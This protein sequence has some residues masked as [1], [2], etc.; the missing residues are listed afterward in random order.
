LV[1]SG[2]DALVFRGT[3]L[4]QT[5]NDLPAGTP[6]RS[7]TFLSSD[8]SISGNRLVVTDQIFVGPGASGATIAAEMDLNGSVQATIIGGPLSIL[9]AVSGTGS[10][11][12]NGNGVLVLGASATFTGTTTIQSGATLQ[13][14]SADALPGAANAGA[15]KVNG[16][17][18]LAGYSATVDGLSGRGLITSSVPGLVTLSVDTTGHASTFSGVIQDGAGRVALT[19][20]GTGLLTLRGNNTFTGETTVGAGSTLRLGS[21]G[22]LPGDPEVNGTL[23]LGGYSATLDGLW[24]SGLVT[25]SVAG[26]VTLTVDT[27]NYPGTFSGVIE[28]GSGTVALTK[29]G[30]GGLTLTGTNTYS[31]GT[32]ISAGVLSVGS[33]GSSGTLGS[34]AVVNN[35]SLVFTRTGTTTIANAISGSGTMTQMSGTVILTGSNTYSGTTTIS[36]TGY[37]N[38]TL[39]IGNGGTTG[40]LGSGTVTSDGYYGSFAQLVY[41]RSDGITASNTITGWMNVTVAAGSTLRA[42]SSSGCGLPDGASGTGIVTINGTFDLN[43][44]SPTVGRLS[45]GGTVT[46]GVS[47]AATLTVDTGSYTAAFSGGIEDGSGTVALTKVGE[48]ELTLTGTNTYSGGT[49]IGAGVLAVGNWGSSGTLGSGAVVNNGS[50]VFKRSGTATVASAISGSGTVTQMSG[51]VILTGSNTYSGTTTIAPTGYENVTLQIGNG[52]TTGTL[53]SGTVTSDG[54]YESFAQLAYNRSDGMTSSNAITGGVNVTVAAGSTLRAGSSAACGLP[55]GSTGTGNATINGVFDLNGYSPTIGLLNGSGTV[56][57]GVSG[58]VTLTVDTGYYTATF[59]GVIEDGSGTVALTKEGDGD[60]R[61]TGTNTYSGDTTISAGVLSVGSWGSSGTLGS[62]A[63]VNNSSLAF[64]RSGTTTVAN[65]ISGS[66]TVTQA[67]GTLTLTG[68]N[69]YTGGTNIILG[70]TLR[71]GGSSGTLGSGAVT[72]VYD[73][74]HSAGQLV[75]DRSVSGTLTNDISGF[76][77]VA[78]QGSGA[79]ALTGSNTYDQATTIGTGSTLCIG[80]GGTAGTVGGGSITVN[81]GGVLAFDRSDEFTVSN[82]ISGS[83]SLS[84]EGSGTLILTGTAFLDGANI[85]DGTLQVEGTVTLTDALTNEGTLRV[86]GSAVLT[87]ANR[88]IS[89]NAAAVSAGEVF[90][91]S[92]GLGSEDATLEFEISTDGVNY[93]SIATG[94]ETD[95]QAMLSGLQAE[96]EYYLRGRAIHGDGSQEI[97]DGG[98]VATLE[99]PGP[100][101]ADTSGWYRISVIRYDYSSSVLEPAPGSTAYVQPRL[102]PQATAEA[103]FARDPQVQVFGQTG[104]PP[105]ASQHIFNLDHSWFFSESPQAAVL[106]AVVGLVQDQSV[107][108]LTNGV[109]KLWHIAHFIHSQGIVFET[110]TFDEGRYPVGG[111]SDAWY[112][113]PYTIG[114][115]RLDPPPPCEEPCESCCSDGADSAGGVCGMPGSSGGS[116]M[117]MPAVTNTGAAPACGSG[118]AGL[119]YAS[120]EGSLDTGFGP[121]WSDADELPVLVG[122]VQNMVARFGA[123]QTVWFDAQENGSYTARHGAKDTLVHD[124]VNDLFILTMPDGSRSEFFDTD[125]TDHPQGGL[126]RWVQPGGATIQ[127]TAWT[128]TGIDGRVAEVLD[129]TT[130][131]GQAYLKREFTYVTTADGLDHVQTLTLSQYDDTSSEWAN[132]RKLTYDY[133]GYDASYGLP[134][135]LKTIVTEQWDATAED[136]VG[137]DTNYFRYYT[138][139]STAHQLKRVVLPNAYAAF[140]A[141]YGDPDDPYNSNAGD[142]PSDPLA[143]YT[144]FYYEYDA[145]GRVT[146]RLVFGKSNETED[147]VTLST[148]SRGVNSWYRKTV[149]SRLDGSTNTVY[150]NF[151]GQAILTD[152]ADSAENH[153]I[154]YHRYDADGRQVLTAEPSAFVAQSGL[155]YDEDMPD[156][157]DYASGA[158][159]YLSNTAG[160]FRETVYYT[161]DGGGAAHGYVYQTAV[162][163]GETAA[164]L[165][166]GST[167]GPIVL[168]SYEYAARTVGD[169]TIHPVAEQTVYTNEDGTGAVTTAYAYTWYSGTFQVQEQTTTLPE[170]E[171]N[172]NGS[173]TSATSKQWFDDRG[174][175]AWT[176]DELGRVTYRQYDSLTGRLRQTIEDLDDATADA[177]QLDIPAGW[178]LPASGGANQTTDYQYDAFGRMTQSLGPAHTADLEGTPTDVRTATWTFYNDAGHETRSAQGYAV[179]SAPE[180]WD[181]FTI[182]GPV[183]IT[184]TDRDGR[185]TGQIQAAYSGT[186]SGLATATIPQSD[187]TAWTAF[188]Y[189]NTRLAAVAVYDD[190]PSGTSDPDAD[191]FVGTAGVNYE[192]TCYGYENFGSSNKG[193][194]NTTVTPDGTITRV[195]FDSRGNVLET[196]LGTDDTGATDTDP[197]GNQATGNNMVKVGSSVFDANGNRI[198]S[199]AYFGSGANDY[200]ATLYQYDWRGRATDV[201]SPADVVTHYELNNLGRRSWTKAYASADF[202]LSTGEL[203]AQAN[204]LY[205]PLGRVYESRVY[206][207]DPDDGTVGDYL[208]SKTWYDPRG[209]VVKTATANGLF[210]KYAYD[211]LGRIVA[212]FTSYDTDETAYAEADD[213]SGDT[214]IQQ[215]LTWYDQAGQTIA[216]AT[217][218]RLPDD[219]GTSGALSAANSY[220]TAT[221]LWYDGLGRTVATADFGREDVDSGLTHYFFDGTSGDPIDEDENGLPDAAEDAPPEPYP[222][223][224]NSLAGIDFQLRLTEYDSAGRAYRTIDNLGRISE[225]QYDDA[226]RTVRSIQN[227]DDGDVDEADTDQD[228]TVDYEYDAGGRLVT[229]T[230]YNPKGSGNGVQS[231]ATKYLY[232]S[233]VNASWQ[234]AAVYPDSTDVL[235]QNSTTKVWSVTTDNGDHVATEY[236]RL[237]R[238]T[239]TT[240]QRG[241]VHEYTF[242]SAGRLAADTVTD[243]GESGIVDDV[244]LRIGRTY[245]D[246]GRLQFVTSYSD[247]SGTTAVNQVKYEYD[248]WGNVVREY[249]EHEATVDG[250][251]PFVQYDYEAGATSGVA[252]Y[253]RLD[254]VVYPDDNRTVDYDYGTVGAIDDIMSRLAAIGDGTDTYA[255]YKYLGAGQI[256]T[257]DYEDIEVNLDHAADNFAALDRFGRVVD[258]AWTDYGANPD[259]V[260]DRYTYEYDRAGNRTARTNELNHDFDETYAYDSLD[261]L[262]SADRDNGFDQSWTLD[263]LGNFSGFDDDGSSQTRSANAAN[264]ITAITGGWVAP[265]YDA[266][267]NMISGPKPGSGTTRV[268]YLYDAWNRLVIVKADDS[269]DPGDTLAEYQY[270]GTNRR[271]EKTVTE[272]GGGPAHVRY[273]Y[274]H[275]WQLLEE[276]FVDEQ[277]ELVVSNQYVWSPRY[278]DAP[279]VRFHDGNAD[280]DYLDAGDSIRYYTGDANY[281]VTATLDAATGDIVE[282][283]V[284]TPYGTATVYSPTWT[285]P[286]GPTADGPL[287]AG[288][289]FDAES[290]LYQVRNR[291]YEP[292]LSRF[293]GRDP[294]LYQG[295]ANLYGYVANRPAHVTDPYGL[296]PQGQEWGVPDFFWWYYFGQGQDVNLSQVG[297]LLPWWNHIQPQVYAALKLNLVPKLESQLDCMSGNTS[298]TIDVTPFT[299]K[300]VA[301]GAITNPLTIMGNSVLK[302]RGTCKIEIECQLC[303][304]GSVEVSNSSGSCD[305]DFTVSDTFQNPLDAGGIFAKNDWPGAK[306]YSLF[307][308]W[309]H[310]YSWDIW[311]NPCPENQ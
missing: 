97:Y 57:T 89:G 186:V 96:T 289:F 115:E 80:D 239:S 147:A 131:T 42:G 165:T 56:T 167:G 228:A 148:H 243:L 169:V 102:L 256:A 219:T 274:T 3:A 15:V 53:G 257:E 304:D 1:P 226:G 49:A 72:G 94:G 238:V 203:R 135:D 55:D 82:T 158:S 141:A 16:T 26:A 155:Y 260:L 70:A 61:L 156:L 173:G 193:R 145:D 227:C 120:R 87:D 187:Y 214:V 191:G 93:Y 223:D 300:V 269:G 39:Q 28:D 184:K 271:I 99:G 11:T 196:W 146:K 272:A 229:M 125:Q 117:R 183:S 202:T 71:V 139:T 59:S 48:G 310:T 19:T 14:A 30:S 235:S 233:A 174:N 241:V 23:D 132:V 303:C 12:G 154:T 65:A 232:T 17:L 261:R 204:S 83:G 190:I 182:V 168:A 297:L 45:G 134:G 270:D 200:Y 244:V 31:G 246:I 100:D 301:G 171:T 177:L 142:G 162:A 63:V 236:D 46:S 29:T 38:V 112:S 161:S 105:P 110:W 33:W 288:Y 2:D 9:G 8:F 144:C 216:T 207:V 266:A 138:G 104:S 88:R 116:L 188:T 123:E 212:S 95:A 84:Q 129:K 213:V 128:E 206:E 218:E 166:P 21:P 78:Q 149:E 62:G 119:T 279:I 175:L 181:D 230:A 153:W 201:L 81:S 121:G 164:R 252:K 58:A 290:A 20:L 292:S 250:N 160:L 85:S 259:T 126:Y 133:Y 234:T 295:G 73:S 114:I 225:T 140:V 283:Y 113:Y 287:Y 86:V 24:G 151:R 170:V 4:T 150:A 172:Q 32:T 298:A 159:P 267:G 76:L 27:T 69:T 7:L 143:N 293:V 192:K 263:G 25:S 18:D 195:V 277:D 264:E 13:L 209:Q 75:F 281:D 265:E 222:Q 36:P 302:V 111:Y 220:A 306:P 64:Q 52:G 37:E 305:L 249:Q 275:D 90:L 118:A 299:I 43:G 224:P 34:G 79:V 163:H 98:I 254:D 44:Y 137:D 122:G 22:A 101:V 106:Q 54:Y 245:D 109:V 205:D 278:I 179:E 124:A 197:T 67:N 68:A 108:V 194:R 262:V 253:V 92:T 35:A 208:P 157:I 251:T 91:S 185:V 60:L 291:Y 176:M 255:A 284:Y 258:Q 217:Y 311:Y 307:A 282:R 10:L 215:G 40:T 189:Q 66:G 180:T 231:Q 152:L 74:Y 178:T 296:K 309:N 107:P 285:N 308:S 247:T 268:H 242:D 77:S 280:G 50:L 47:G 51:T 103:L 210:Q 237:G 240:D 41:N 286:A 273:C 127:V 136:W 130:P 199:H 6:F 248:S 5:E 198:A 276:R 221:L 211:G 294:I